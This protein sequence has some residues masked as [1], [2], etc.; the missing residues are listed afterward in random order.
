[1]QDDNNQDTANMADE[2]LQSQG[3]SPG[4]VNAE[5]RDELNQDISGSA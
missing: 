1:M 2:T 4:E 5:D 3:I